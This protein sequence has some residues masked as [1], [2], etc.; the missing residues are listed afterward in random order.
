[1]TVGCPN[2]FNAMTTPNNTLMYWRK[3]N[4][5][6]INV[7]IGQVMAT[8]NKE[9]LNNYVVHVP[10]WLWQFVPHCFIMP[11]HILKKPSKK[12]HQIFNASCK[13]DWDSSPI[14]SMT[15]TPHGLELSCNLGRVCEDVLIIA[16]NLRISYPNDDIIIHANDE[17]SCFC[18]IKHHPDVVG[19]FSYVLSKLPILPN[20]AG[21]WRRLHP[22]QL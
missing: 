18:Q 2:H 10:H 22:I 12:D 19:A 4:H 14:N 9:E 1:M 13:Y 20:R 11:Q 21:L 16:Y 17:K 8:M 5:H 3:G 6:F 7:K 15:S